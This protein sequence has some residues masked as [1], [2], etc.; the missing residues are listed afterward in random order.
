MKIN[1]VVALSAALLISGTASAQSFDGPRAEARIGFDNPNF[2][3][4][5]EDESIE[6]DISGVMFGAELGYDRQFGAGFAGAYVGA[7]LSRA[8]QCGE[9]FGEDELCT[10][11][12]RNFTVGARLGV[13][14]ADGVAFYAKGGYSNGRL[15]TTYEDFEGILDDE[16]LS[17]TRGGFHLGGGMEIAATQNVYVRGEYVMTNY[18]DASVDGITADI[19]RDQFILGVGMRF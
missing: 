10:K 13:I 14:A 17:N 11:M 19:D 9:L 5:F 15:K 3:I 2:S 6:A 12:D 8:R 4:G 7:E 16:S 18:N 1:S